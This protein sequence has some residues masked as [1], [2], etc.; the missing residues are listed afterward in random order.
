M[1]DKSLYG[2]MECSNDSWQADCC[3]E[4]E[5]VMSGTHTI[6]QMLCVI[7]RYCSKFLIWSS[8]ESVSL[9]HVWSTS[10]CQCLSHVIY[11]SVSFS[12]MCYQFLS[13]WW[14][15]LISVCHCLIWHKLL[16]VCHWLIGSSFKY[17]SSQMET[18]IECHCLICGELFRV[19]TVLYTQD[20]L[21][22]I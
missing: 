18:T 7:H 13:M 22:T 17:M 21:S 20:H 11:I 16:S 3:V 9:I 1:T 14:H 5:G 2:S 10:K 8:F 6:L 19:A 4:R 15:Q 12:H